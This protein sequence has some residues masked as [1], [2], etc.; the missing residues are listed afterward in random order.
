MWWVAHSK[1]DSVFERILTEV[2]PKIQ[3][4]P[5]ER[6][7]FDAGIHK[8][9]L[10]YHVRQGNFQKGAD[11]IPQAAL[12]MAENDLLPIWKIPLLLVFALQYFGEEKYDKALDALAEIEAD[13]SNSYKGIASFCLILKLLIYYEKNAYL[14]LTSTI[15]NVH[16]HLKKKETLFEFEK[17]L[18]KCLKKA[19][20][21]PSRKEIIPFL[22]SVKATLLDLQKKAKGEELEPY[23]YFNYIAWLESKIEQT[24]F[25]EKAKKYAYLFP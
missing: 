11:Y 4:S 5:L 7:R 25:E 15:R 6:L 21:L 22:K 8:A 16:Y 23:T 18:L 17:Y 10:T 9:T 14:L 13:S 19:I 2:Q 3:L 1:E 12:F 24:S 20:N